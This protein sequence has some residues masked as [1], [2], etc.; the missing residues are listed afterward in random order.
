M[1]NLDPNQIN[2]HIEKS[3]F[4]KNPDDKNDPIY[5]KYKDIAELLK[6][7]NSYMGY[8]FYEYLT[9][10]NY[11]D[12][13]SFSLACSSDDKIRNKLAVS[14]G[15]KLMNEIFVNGVDKRSSCEIRKHLDKNSFIREINLNFIECDTGNERIFI[16]LAIAPTMNAA[17]NFYKSI[18]INTKFNHKHTQKP[19]ASFHLR[20][21]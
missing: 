10:L 2:N 8:Q 20:D 12:I 4:Q 1:Y 9:I 18:S 13:E 3:L 19:Y 21:S 6:E 11:L 14:V 7:T 5:K 16:S 15:Y 17:R